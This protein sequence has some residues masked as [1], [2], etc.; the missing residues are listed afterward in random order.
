MNLKE[1]RKSIESLI[2]KDSV[3][4]DVVYDLYVEFV[5]EMSKNISHKYKDVDA[6]NIEMLDEAVDLICDY[7]NGS[8]KVIEV[9]D[10]IWDAK[11]DKRKISGDVVL[12][13]LDVVKM[14]EKLY[15][16]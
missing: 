1:I 13:F 10:A 2:D 16:V 3:D 8:S 7:L 14:A 6:W 9:W 4:V 15:G 5:K 11:I 12:K